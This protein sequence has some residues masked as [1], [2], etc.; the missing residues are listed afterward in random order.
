MYILAIEQSTSISSVSVLRQGTVIG[1][2]S[3][4]ESRSHHQQLFSE[5]PSHLQSMGITSSDISTFAVGTGPGAFSGLRISLSTVQGLALPGNAVV[6]GVPSAQ[7][8]AYRLA[9]EHQASHI[10]IIG[11]ARRGRLWFASFCTEVDQCALQGDIRLIGRDDLK[12][13]LQPDTLLASPDWLRLADYLHS[14]QLPDIRMIEQRCTPSASAVGH[15]AWAR[16]N[17]PVTPDE[18]VP[19]YLHPP[20]FV[21]PKFA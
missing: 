4:E 9:K 21:E 2:Q 16:R 20:V 5:L 15:L 7:A 13:N 3:W 6:R 11:D 18:L 19:I 12:Q 8:L 14:L 17:T 10:T 1:E